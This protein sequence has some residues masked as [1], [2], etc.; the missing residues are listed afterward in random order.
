MALEQTRTGAWSDGTD[1]EIVS[2]QFPHTNVQTIRRGNSAHD[3][4]ASNGGAITLIG[5]KIRS[6]GDGAFGPYASGEGSTITVTGAPFIETFGAGAD[7]AVADTGGAVSLMNGG[8]IVTSGTGASGV[9]TASGGSA[10]L[11]GVS[12]STAGDSAPG[13]WASGDFESGTPST[14]VATAV[15]VTT[16]VGPGPGTDAVGV[17]ANAVGRTWPLAG[18]IVSMT[19]GAIA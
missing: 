16:G 2:G 17:L 3:I 7:G 15:T 19:S 12:V 13:L 9:Y 5:G 1:A 8:Q 6:N 4:Y 18:E 11:S 10:V 14:I